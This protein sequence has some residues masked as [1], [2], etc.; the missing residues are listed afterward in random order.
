MTV[1]VVHITFV[2]FG[3]QAMSL[4]TRTALLSAHF[5]LLTL[6]PLFYVHGLD[7][8]TWLAIAGLTAP[9]DETY[10]GLI[11]G[12]LGAWLAAIPIPLD[13]DREWQ[14][15]P[16]TIVTGLYVG[17]LLGKVLGG[18]MFFGW[19]LAKPEKELTSPPKGKVS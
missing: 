12:A 5:S 17:Y 11:G 15:W 8:T 18:S 14:K 7:S 1:P 6:F 3:A 10:G 19:R 4:I 13:W 2:L 9:L 16:V